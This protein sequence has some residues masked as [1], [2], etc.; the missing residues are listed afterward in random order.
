VTVTAGHT[1]AG[2][3]GGQPDRRLQAVRAGSAERSTDTVPAT[4]RRPTPRWLR[5]Y[6]GAVLAL[7]LCAAL[8]GGVLVRVLGFGTPGAGVEAYVATIAL[9]L[10]WLVAVHLCRGYE[11][12]DLTSGAQEFQHVLR[13]GVW[14]MAAIAFVSYGV[15][16]NFGR[17][18]VLVAVPTAALASVVSRFAARKG[19]HRL[20][21]SGRCM[22]S[23]VAVGRERA[24][25]DLVTQFRG[26]PACGMRVDAACVTDPAGARLLREAGVTI[27]GD[28]EAAA[29]V[30]RSTRADAVAV[31][32]SSETAASYLRRLSWELEGSGVELLVAPGLMEIAGP[33]MRIRPFVGL[34]LLQVDEPQFTGARRLIK[35]ALDRLLATGA[36]LVFAPV[37]LLIALAVRLD[38]EGPALFRQTRIGRGGQEFVMVKFRTMSVDAESRRDELA[39]AN[40]NADG[41]LFK[42]AAD[43]RVT[44]VGRVLRRYSLDELPQLFNVL[45][46]QMALVG[47]RPPLPT[48]VALYDDSVRRRLLVKPGL[49]GLWQVSGRSDLSWDESVRLDLRYVE[50][51][52]LLLDVMILWKTAFAVVRA[53]GA[54]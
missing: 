31:T 45:F 5:R 36:L 16:L 32:S 4:K 49:T 54:Y 18:F 2:H 48:E 42:V 24:V 15:G 35:G 39:A 14:A 22:K 13:A 9:A 47:P 41:L 8:L 3:G 43:P 38:S 6:L 44:R 53:R 7:D 50:N 33:R 37:L 40:Q 30:V 25:L 46:G 1:R 10:C 21:A 23:V 27:L 52:S 28:L 20:R 51:W 11:V 12:E 34:P 29:E 26:D 19:V 17:G